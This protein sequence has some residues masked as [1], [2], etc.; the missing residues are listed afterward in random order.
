IATEG[1]LGLTARRWC[2]KNRIPFSTS[3]HTLFPEYVSARLPIPKSWLYSFVRWFHGGGWV[4]GDAD[5]HDRLVREIDN[6]A[7][8]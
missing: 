3:Y 2:L 5:T 1:P 4:L 6:G 7:D 8:A